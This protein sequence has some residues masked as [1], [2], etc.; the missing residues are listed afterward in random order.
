[1]EHWDPW[2]VEN[3][4]RC[5]SHIHWPCPF[6]QEGGPPGSR[7]LHVSE[8]GTVDVLKDRIEEHLTGSEKVQLES[9]P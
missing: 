2:L 8:D 4:S 5:F 1:M 7:A 3:S 9:S 6:L